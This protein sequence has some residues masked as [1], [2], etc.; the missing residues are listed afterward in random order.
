[1]GWITGTAVYIIIW[2]LV[3][4]MVLPWGV[5]PIEAEDVAR[6][7][8]SGAPQRPAIL[9]KVALTS[10]AAAVLWLGVYFI[11]NSGMISFRT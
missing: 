5:R 2:W 4:F 8:A 11:I 1:M 3:L 6:G 10:L 9:L 7:H